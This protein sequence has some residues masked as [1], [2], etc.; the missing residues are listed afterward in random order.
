MVMTKEITKMMQRNSGTP[1][2]KTL[3]K[4]AHEL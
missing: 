1:F 2:G 4:R 3:W